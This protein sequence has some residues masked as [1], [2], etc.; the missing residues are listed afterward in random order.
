MTRPN[1]CP[2]QSP[3]LASYY[4]VLRGAFDMDLYI[5]SLC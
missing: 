4:S 1:T 2:A 5:D 3:L